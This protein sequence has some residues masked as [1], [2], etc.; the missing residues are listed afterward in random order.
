MVDSVTGEV[1][2]DGVSA[3]LIRTGSQSLVAAA[4]PAETINRQVEIANELAK[5]V[6][7]RKLYANV[8]GKRFVTVSG[9]QLLGHM[10]SVTAVVVDTEPVEGGFMA[11]VEARRTTD[12]MTVGRAQ[13]LC[14]DDEKSGPWRTADRYARLSMAQT[15]ATSKALRQA[16]GP[17][18]QLAG[19]EGTPAEEMPVETAPPSVSSGQA[20]SGVPGS[21]GG[22]ASGRTSGFASPKQQKM[23]QFVAHKQILTHR[24]F[25]H[26]MCEATNK[27]LTAEQAKAVTA[28]WIS[29]ALGRLPWTAVDATKTALDR[30]AGEERDGDDKSGRVNSPYAQKSA[31][32]WERA[33]ETSS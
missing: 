8:K 3:E 10:C 19:F 2:D 24:Q 4:T 5:V 26:A 27:T 22:G 29:E 6:E 33:K 17:I 31:D 21:A 12:G 11:T 1:I 20:G 23:L 15:R 18:M 30:M 28:Q 7:D 32:E 14:T 9:W 25:A 13:A 16:L